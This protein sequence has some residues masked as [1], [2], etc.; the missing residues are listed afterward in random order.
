MISTS[1]GS[2]PRILHAES[3]RAVINGNMI[4]FPRK[5][6]NKKGGA[7]GKN[8]GERGKNFS[9]TLAKIAFMG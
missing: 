5:K 7:K 4:A 2:I 6:S 9:I 1:D 8:F 3:L